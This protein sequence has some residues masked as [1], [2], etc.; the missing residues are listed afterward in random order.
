[1]GAEQELIL[2]R[3]IKALNKRYNRVNG[4]LCSAV[5]VLERL[6]RKVRVGEPVNCDIDATLSLLI[7][8]II[9]STD[10][11]NSVIEMVHDQLAKA[12]LSKEAYAQGWDAR[13]VDL[14]AR[15][16]PEEAVIIHALLV[17]EDTETPF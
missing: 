2:Q 6:G 14:L 5:D 8:A 11:Q 13:L 10:L 1:V 9:D 17:E 12:E 4:D 3:V 15:A 16:T 7:N